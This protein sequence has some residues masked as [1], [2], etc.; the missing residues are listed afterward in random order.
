MRTS[1]Y[2]AAPSLPRAGL[3]RAV[4]LPPPPPAL[5]TASTLT[6]R[7]SQT[8]FLDIEMQAM[9]QAFASEY[10]RRKPPKPVQFI[11]AFLIEVPVLPLPPSQGLLVLPGFER[12]SHSSQPSH[13]SF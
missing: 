6:A 11:E 1:R 7:A 9:C 10:N 13:S 4:G 2:A 3:L 8:Y 12:P 5:G